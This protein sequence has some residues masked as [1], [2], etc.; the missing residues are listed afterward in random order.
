MELFPLS[1]SSINFGRQPMPQ[2]E[3]MLVKDK[4][5]CSSSGAA[6]FS[7]IMSVMLTPSTRKY[8][9]CWNSSTLNVS[10]LSVYA[11]CWNLTQHKLGST[12]MTI[13]SFCFSSVPLK[14]TLASSLLPLANNGRSRTLCVSPLMLRL[15]RSLGG[16][17]K[18]PNISG[19]S[20]CLLGEMPS[21]LVSYTVM[22]R[23]WRHSFKSLIARSNLSRGHAHVMTMP[24][25]NMTSKKTPQL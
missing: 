9:R 23:D 24:L 1:W 19:S 2:R 4:M 7:K 18:R 10:V 8:F 13:R 20:N 6:P 5:I 12:A 22:E 14:V 17:T 11:L 21:L 3:H 15:S 25:V 16:C